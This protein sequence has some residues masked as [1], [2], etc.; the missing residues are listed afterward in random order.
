[1][2]QS[3]IQ[4][5]V[6]GSE[7]SLNGETSHLG[8]LLR[9][10]YVTF[11]IFIVAKLSQY[12]TVP[13][14]NASPIWPAAG[15]ALAV[16]IQYGPRI[17]LGIFLG[18]TLFEFHLFGATADTHDLYSQFMLATGLGIGTAVQALVGAQLVQR[19]LGPLPLLVRNQE[20]FHFQLLAGPIACLVSATISISVLW[21]LGIVVKEELLVGW[22]TWWVG[23]TIGV[24]IFAPLMLIYLNQ[25]QPLWQGREFTV[26]FPMLL[27]FFSVIVFY[28][29]SNYKESEE[30]Q[31][32]F[33]KQARAY[34]HT[35]MRAFQ[36][37]IAILESLK[38]HF[39]ASETVHRSGFKIV[40]Q[41]PIAK[42]AGIQAL[43]WIP[44]IDHLQR[45]AFEHT[46]PD[47]GTIRHLQ[48][49]G[50]LQPA[51]DRTEYYAIQYIEP[52]ED[53]NT[54]FGFDITSN[55]LAAEALFRARDSGKIAAT[56]PLHLVQETENKL[57]IALYNP[58]YRTTSTPADIEQ[59]RDS[60]IG[61][62]AAIFR[63]K[64]L[65]DNELTL[66]KQQTIA[67][68]LLDVTEEAEPQLLFTNGD[69]DS[70]NLKHQ[71]S[72]IHNID[73][74]GR[75]W[76]LEYT[77]TNNFIAEN[78][79]WGM[80]IVLTGGLMVTALFGTVLLMLTGHTQRMEE[81]VLERT[82]ELRN[83]VMQRR[84]AETQLRQ[85]LDG[86]ELGFWDW[87][88]ET[89]TQW[90]N[91]RWMEIL[92]IEQRELKSNISDF[93]ERIHPQ[94]RDKTVTI[95]KQHIQND[96]A[97]V[98]EFRMQHQK[99]HW[100]WIQ[101]AGAVVSHDPVSLRPLRLCGTLQDITERKKQE[102]HILHQAHYDSLT[103]LPNRFLA[104]DRLSQL[105]NEAHRNK[106]KVAVLFLDLDDF[107]KINDTLGHETGDKLL[108]EAASRLQSV[109]RDTDTVGRLGGDEFIILIGGLL[110]PGNIQHVADALCNKFT[111][112]FAIDN[113]ELVLTAS[114]GISI[115]PD[116]GKNL[117][118]LLRNADTAMYHSKELGRNTYSY[119][120]D[121]MNQGVS[122]RLLLEEQ[123][124]G[125]LNRAEFK[126]YY[127]T[128]VAIN[129][130]R[131]IGAE[132]LLRWSNPVLGDV[133]PIEFIPIAEDTGMIVSIGKLVMTEALRIL[134]K[135]QSM[136]NHPITMAVNLSPRQFR[137]PNLVSFIEQ[138][139]HQFELP[140]ESLELE[141]TEGV[142]MSGHSYIDDA[143]NAL[144]DL[145]V[146][147]AMD[148]FGTGYSSLSYLRSYPFNVIKIDREF[149]NDLTQ[150]PRDRELVSAA[151]AMAQGLGLKVVAEGVETEA[152]L[153]YLSNWGCNYGQGYLFS[154]PVTAEEITEILVSM[155]TDPICH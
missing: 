28:S 102:A 146:S 67:V 151:I 138:T 104:L 115:Y 117:S 2:K 58:V 124:H 105:I 32:K 73:M 15:I 141:I 61:V 93:I 109:I 89:G 44:K 145:G 7:I 36:T 26:A 144:N 65:I 78:T 94:D 8:W 80:W 18:S 136:L 106:K 154:K 52:P 149:I 27:L 17:V 147:I 3:H 79:T 153:E 123:M 97:Y 24:M 120:T 95:I 55:P 25:H 86:A 64:N 39:N 20:I 142:L 63:I 37:H 14:S 118:E 87:N 1:L 48:H 155:D 60:I 5:V 113:R 100:L 38:S 108:T 99:G 13:P 4:P 71:L 125:A 126:L 66:L 40:T 137:D 111:E 101:A 54:A 148:D 22:I 57:G 31:L 82:A 50:T 133:S 128:K 72:E 12:L 59:R 110:E 132:A 96:T 77:A 134:S 75:Q 92:G 114:I 121:K 69:Q 49:D 131:I 129:N 19:T 35:L 42:H 34:H 56:A 107:K 130:R 152:Q 29:Y 88:Y 62:V 74:G 21:T 81:E 150:D 23:D 33:H 10:L 116:N 6:S 46:L 41:T 122:R 135:W 43:E 85:V 139:L 47:G 51:D 83:E 103:G 91:D 140:A 143:L 112:A 16:A 30:K 127:Q 53:N 76:R 119:F 98:V 45:N 68:R 11:C 9:T 84:D 70:A 90:V